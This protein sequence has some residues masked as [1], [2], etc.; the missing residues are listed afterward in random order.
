MTKVKDLMSKRVIYFKPEDTIF[1]AAKVFCKKKISGAPVVEDPKTKKVVGVISESDIVKFMGTS[2][3]GEEK[4]AGDFT[5]QSL[6]LLF[7]NFIRMSKNLLSTKKQI[8]RISRIKVKDVMS[9]DVISVSSDTNIFDA[10]SK[11]DIHDV[12]RLPVIDSG[13]LVGI[14]ARADLLKALL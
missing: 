2:L 4:L 8:S 9:K 5:Y 6:T 10:A 1:R 3:G 11:M 14:I 12:N 13:Q 7:F